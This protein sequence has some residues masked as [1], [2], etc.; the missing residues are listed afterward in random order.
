[1]TTEP[2]SK[3]ECI[4]VLTIRAVPRRDAPPI[5]RL[6]R[7]LKVLLRVYGWQVVECRQTQG[8]DENG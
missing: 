2:G 8:C 3:S 1:M 6:R 4:V 7:L 5:I